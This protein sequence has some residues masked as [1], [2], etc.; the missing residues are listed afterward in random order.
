MNDGPSIA[1]IAAAIGEHARAEILAVLMGGRAATASEL[2]V[3]AG[4]TKQTVSSHL[5]TLRDAGLLAMEKRGRH[6]YFRLANDDVAHLLESLMGVAFRTGAV[7]L[8]PSPREPSLRKARV[9]YDHLAGDLGVMV[10]DGLVAHQ[11]IREIDSCLQLTPS[12]RRFLTTLD[13]ETSEFPQT[14]RPMCRAC[15][16]WSVRRY[17]LAGAVGAALL[18]CFVEKGWAR[19]AKGSRVVTF[20]VAGEEA[21][22]ERFERGVARGKRASSD[23]TRRAVH[24]SG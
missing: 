12:G 21:L 9:C 17:H 6:R 3:V 20:S 19:R 4:V 2:A 13:I 11:H 23:A 14:R 16:D 7:R 18:D 5:A 15:L 22:R 1:R 10:Y 8:R 24:P